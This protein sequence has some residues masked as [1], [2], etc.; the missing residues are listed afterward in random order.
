MKYRGMIPSVVALFAL[1][2]FA[3]CFVTGDNA[4][5]RDFLMALFTAQIINLLQSLYE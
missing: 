3:Y 2:A 5:G 1:L 4:T